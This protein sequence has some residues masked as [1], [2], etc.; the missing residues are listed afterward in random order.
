MHV[1]IMP[2]LVLLVERL[3]ELGFQPVAIHIVGKVY[4]TVPSTLLKLRQLGVMVHREAVGDMRIGA[5]DSAI[6]PVLKRVCIESSEFA[7]RLDVA[8]VIL[9]DDGGLLSE[10]WHKVGL[11]DCDV[12]SVQQT[13]SGLFGRRRPSAS[14]YIKVDVARSAAKAYFES[15]IIALGVLR[16]AENLRLLEGASSVGIIGLGRLGR[17][18]CHKLLERRLEV[19]G[20]DPAPGQYGGLDIRRAR[21]A[22]EVAHHADIVF[23]CSGRPSM[24]RADIGQARANLRLVSC[25]SRDVEFQQVLQSCRLAAE[26]YDQPF[27]ALRLY[28]SAEPCTVLNG[29]FPINFDRQREWET[30]EEISLTRALVLLGVLQALCARDQVE[31]GHAWPLDVQAQIG[32]IAAW[33]PMVERRFADFGVSRWEYESRDWWEKRSAG[34]LAWRF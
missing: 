1:H 34:P 10:A 6:D 20:Y 3:I 4:S 9:V 32:V 2:S 11:A 31:L 12:V 23:G 14:P 17:S 26:E 16:S 25:S 29:G 33:L 24:S 8:R 18:L 15:R 30:V 21:G 7:A 28:C 27:E 13:A 5:Y 22:A 19:W